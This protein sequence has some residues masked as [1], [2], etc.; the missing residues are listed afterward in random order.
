MGYR[1]RTCIGLLALL[2]LGATPLATDAQSLPLT[3]CRLDARGVPAVFARCGTLAVPENPAEPGGPTIDLFVARVGALSA[4]PRPD[5]LLLIAGGPGQS[6]VDFYLQLRGA[7]EGAR[8]DRDIVL[9]DQRGTGRSAAGFTC[10]TPD[11]LALDTASPEALGRVIDACKAELKHDAR[12][13]TTSV[14]VRDLDRVRAGLGI[15]RWNVYGVSYGTRVAQHYL[16]RFPE[17]T[18]AVVLDGVVPPDLALGPDV[19]PEAQRALTQIFG[20]CAAD[21]GCAAKFPDLPAHFREL[22]A[23]LDAAAHD[24]GTAKPPLSALEL[25]ALVRFM[26]YSSATVSLLPVLLTE[27]YGGN[28]APLA[29]HAKTTLRDLPEALSFPM[30]N[31][32]TCTED[33]PF[34]DADATK[35]LAGTYLG[36]AIVDALR[37]ICGRW[38]VGVRDDD[39]KQPVISEKPVLLLSGDSDPITPPTYAERVIVDGLT[40]SKHLIGRNQGHGLVGIGC[41]PRLLRTFLE[42]AS[43]KDLDASCLDAEPAP[44][45]FL[46]LLGPAP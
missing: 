33:V 41:V 40:N 8:R 7:F 16:R 27:A 30:S 32:V 38:P 4:T 2:A 46:S 29:S 14:A 20:R 1:R 26:S 12:Y 3:R 6:T 10:K 17:R 37:L 11:D 19:A 31:S 28:Y 9:V 43:P 22:L 42:Q 45:F 35:D 25:R 15:E 18:R 39:F 24:T 5:P 34:I 36:T 21:A 44:P 13:Y 23:R